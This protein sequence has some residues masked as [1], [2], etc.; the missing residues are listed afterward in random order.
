MDA[1]WLQGV[2]PPIPTAFTQSG[3]LAEP[4]RPFLEHLGQG[5]V[6]GVVGLGSNG[7][8]AH[9][10]DSERARALAALR[11]ALP[12]PLRLIA[13]TGA[14]STRATIERTRTAADQGAEA[15]LVIAPSYYRRDLTAA[16]LA[17]HYEAVAEASPIPILIYNVPVNMGYDLPDEWIPELARHPNVVGLKDSSGNTT[18]LPGL[19][20]QLGPAFIILAGA[21]EKMVDAMGSGADGAIAAL[22]NLAPA[23]CARIRQHMLVGDVESAAVVQRTIAPLGEALSKRYGVAGLKAALRLQGFD[24]GPPRA[25]LPAL[26]EAELPHLRQLLNAAQRLPEPLPS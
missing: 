19:R 22:A 26:D 25:P 10:T 20:A 1:H 2:F 12:A 11:A 9:L 24:H 5:G 13:G 4:V 6:D 17:A 3:E 14:D 21:G 23:A 18:R 8:A 16:G 15:A 7:E